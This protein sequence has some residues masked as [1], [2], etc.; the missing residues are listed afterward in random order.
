[1]RSPNL[2][3]YEVLT[4]KNA[5]L[6]LCL[7]VLPLPAT[8]Q[9]PTDDPHAACAAVGYVPRELLEKPVALR[10]GTGAGRGPGQAHDPVT[11]A[12]PEAQAFYDQGVAYLHSYVWIEAARA[13]RQALRLDPKLALAHVGLSRVATA[14][15]AR[16]AALS[17]RAVATRE[18]PTWASASF[19]SRRSAWRKARAASIQT[20]E[21]K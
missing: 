12:S 15:E 11:S 5:L 16:A 7:V 10:D 14:L 9:V 6:S 2:L 3:G 18:S 4:L 21:C 13:L 8:A 1:M 17:S 19:G 20:Y